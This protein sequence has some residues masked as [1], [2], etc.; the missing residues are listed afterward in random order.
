M[1]EHQIFPPCR[2]TLLRPHPFGQTWWS[3]RRLD[4]RDAA[5]ERLVSHRG[6]RPKPTPAASVH[7]FENAFRPVTT[8][9]NQSEND[10]EAIRSRIH[11]SVPL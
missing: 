6:L 2:D 8:K 3:R 11:S 4:L 1:L 9:L 5:Q 7:W 10:A